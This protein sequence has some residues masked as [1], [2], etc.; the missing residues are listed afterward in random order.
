MNA[1][2]EVRVIVQAEDLAALEGEWWELWRRC[3]AATPF[4]T[5]AWC[6]PWWDAFAPGRLACVALRVAGRL[7]ALAPLY[8]EDSEH[9]SRL[10]PIGIGVTDY[11]DVLIE[12][13]AG[14]DVA[15]ALVDGVAV[16]VPDW[17]IWELEEMLPGAAGLALPRPAGCGDALA[18]QSAC[19][20][21][22]LA[23]DDSSI[24]A[25]KRRKLRM[26]EHR[27]ARRGGE[28]RAVAAAEI[29]RFLGDLVRL[30]GAR[31]ASRD[32]EGVMRDEAVLRFHAAAIPRLAAAGLARLFE[33]RVDG[34]VIGAYY[35]LADADRA[36]AYLGGF[37]PAF[38]F[39]SPGTVLVGH[40]IEAAHRDGAREFHFLRG[41]EAYKYEWGAA[42][43]WNR[44]RSLQRVTS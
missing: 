41:R 1:S 6:L 31:W 30:H 13:G 29:P 36:Y 18:E 23:P 4:A 5:P 39:E 25:R 32:G 44:R 34:H 9:G 35:G 42:D 20:V 15:R 8:L 10:L 21:L 11:L 19:P 38:A 27:L 28:V 33:A 22:P 2:L 17:R 26:A 3:P 7:A 43:R 24:P 12:P 37:D 14:E 40:A 16:R